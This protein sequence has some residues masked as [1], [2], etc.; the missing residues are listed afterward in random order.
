[1]STLASLRGVAAGAGRA[2]WREA[3]GR[4]ARARAELARRAALAREAPPEGVRGPPLR[5]L[6]GELRHVAGIVPPR[7][8]EHPPAQRPR[9]VM[10]L[11]G[12][13]TSHWRMRRMAKAL[14]AAGHAAHDWGLGF[15]LGPTP[16]N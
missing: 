9:P 4:G 11:P 1:M 12:F 7:K 8:A 3:S 6:V 10:I 13:G 2:L 16:E 14:A 15:N 5:L